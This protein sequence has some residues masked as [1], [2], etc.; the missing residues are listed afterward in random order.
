MEV[1]NLWSDR[2]VGAGY[3]RVEVG[4]TVLEVMCDGECG[5]RY[6]FDYSTS[7]SPREIES[8]YGGPVHFLKN[9]LG[10]KC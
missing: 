2:L 4:R 6:V 8:V 5:Y 7:L 9:F 1:V 10:F 3:K